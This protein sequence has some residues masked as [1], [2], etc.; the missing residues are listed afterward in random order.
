[1]TKPTLKIQKGLVKKLRLIRDK[2]NVDIQHMT[3]QE[4]KEYLTQL[5]S[6]WKN[7]PQ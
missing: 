1:M 6:K 2:I 5:V 7:A 3:L 4:E